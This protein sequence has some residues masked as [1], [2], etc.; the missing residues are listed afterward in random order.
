MLLGGLRGVILRIMEAP[1]RILEALDT[2]LGLLGGL[3]G[4][5]WEYFGDIWELLG[6]CLGAMLDLGE[7]I[8]G[9][10]LKF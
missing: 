2:L 6:S 10:S 8:S 1:K 5:S 3:L 4:G 7:R 9:D